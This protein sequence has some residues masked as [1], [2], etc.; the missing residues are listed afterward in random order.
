LLCFAKLVFSLA[1]TMQQCVAKSQSHAGIVL[2]R[3]EFNP[4]FGTAL[5][6]CRTVSFP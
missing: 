3:V 4:S 2:V 5:C 1:I 6:P